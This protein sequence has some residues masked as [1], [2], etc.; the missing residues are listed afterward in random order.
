MVLGPPGDREDET[1]GLTGASA[2]VGPESY[3]IWRRTRL[4]AITEASEIELIFQL[5]GPLQG[6][7]L[8]DAGCGDGFYLVEAARRG[9]QVNGVDISEAMLIVARRRASDA[10]VNVELHRG[11]IEALPF[12]DDTFHIVT[13]ITVLCFVP[14]PRQAVDEMARVL[15]PGGRL[16]IGELGRWNTWAAWRRLRGWLGSKTWQRATFHSGRQ[17]IDLVE[18]AGLEV[19]DVRGAIYYPPSGLAAR[20]FSRFE[21]RLG[22]ATILGA[23]FV[24]VTAVKPHG[25]ASSASCPLSLVEHCQCVGLA[26]SGPSRP[27]R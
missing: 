6:R 22:W 9:A 18:A 12:E 1:D 16:V 7:R 21:D 8:L 14:D 11:D 27:T 23:A 3:D 4:G 24:A 17:L 15:T 13:A 19:E 20:L 25:R 26:A 10:G 5:A 2:P